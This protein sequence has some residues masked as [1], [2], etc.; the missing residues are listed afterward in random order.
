MIKYCFPQTDTHFVN[1]TICTDTYLTPTVYISFFYFDLLALWPCFAWKYFK[2]SFTLN[3]HFEFNASAH[4]EWRNG[5][6][7]RTSPITDWGSNR[8]ICH[9]R[10]HSLNIRCFGSV[11]CRCWHCQSLQAHYQLIARRYRHCAGRCNSSLK[12]KPCFASFVQLYG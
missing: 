5:R 2:I 4:V 7:Q 3:V 12:R 11:F 6:C 10:C 9:L 1:Q 8:Q